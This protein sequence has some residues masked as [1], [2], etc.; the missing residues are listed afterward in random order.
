MRHEDRELD[1][2]NR[3]M[4]TANLEPRVSISRDIGEATVTHTIFGKAKVR[5]VRKY[6]NLRRAMW[7]LVTAAL[8]A[9]A[10]QAWLAFRPVEPLQSADPF[11]SAN[12]PEQESQP[13]H[14]PEIAAPS[15]E[16]KP[17]TAPAVAVAKPV[18]NQ[19]TVPHP[20]PGFKAAA[21][22]P[23]KPVAPRPLPIIKPQSAPLAASS[24]PV[25]IQPPKPLPPKPMP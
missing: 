8:A 25:S 19:Q 16:S 5:I 22:I 6:D 12:A 24:R 14:L 21:P 1:I 4:L 7:L 3:Q 18:I 11:S 9:A 10:W 17:V 2:P 20:A 15:A 23:A 13:V